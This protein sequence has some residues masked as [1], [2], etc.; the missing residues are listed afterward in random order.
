MFILSSISSGL[1]C[2]SVNHTS[3]SENSDWKSLREISNNWP[4]NLLGINVCK[5]LEFCCELLLS[6]LQWASTTLLIQSEEHFHHFHLFFVLLLILP[7]SSV[8]SGVKSSR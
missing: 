5:T 6:I 2:W 8:V 1:E 3:I 7:S 4:N